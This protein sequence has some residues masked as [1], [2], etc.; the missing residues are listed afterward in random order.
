[1]ALLMLPASVM[2]DASSDFVAKAKQNLSAHQNELAISNLTQAIELAPKNIEAYRLRA[3]VFAIMGQNKQCLSD[4]TAVIQ[5][6]PKNPTNYF[7][8]ALI[9]G[10]LDHRA[11]AIDD[12]SKAIQL[13][14]KFV[15]AYLARG[16]DYSE[17]GDYTNAIK[18]E[19]TAIE[20]NPTASV[21]YACRGRTY[22]YMRE[23]EKALKEFDQAIEINP[24]DPK[25]YTLRATVYNR[26]GKYELAINDC[27]EAISLNKKKMGVS[28]DDPESYFTRAKAFTGKGDYEAAVHDYNMVISLIPKY[29]AA[30][31]DL[32]LL[33][34]RQGNYKEGI[35][36]CEKAVELAPNIAYGHNNLA[37]I[38]AIC[39]E[40]SLRDGA[41]ALEEAKRA[42]E[43]TNWKDP[44]CIGTLAAAYAETGSFVNA[45]KWEKKSIDMGLP[46]SEM[47][48]AQ[49]YLKLY[50]E[51]KPYHEGAFGVSIAQ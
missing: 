1:M 50:E 47:T 43:L 35:A 29:S 3:P 46:K 24:D 31:S 19:T 28:G 27:N 16:A 2:A 41:R 20:L 34:V 36:N 5:L 32:G 13:S 4:F 6:D 22:A 15:D 40:A 44:F 37:W 8:R 17:T 23:F 21:A 9:W 18:D 49:K 26:L 48:N 12:Y 33:M 25:V 30:Y 39:P 10:R 7:N 42:C 14:P 45:V 51:K 38:L 11:Q